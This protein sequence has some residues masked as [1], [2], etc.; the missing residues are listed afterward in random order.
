MLS[1]V[2][3]EYLDSYIFYSAFTAV[4][5]IS[6]EFGRHVESENKSENRSKSFNLGFYRLNGFREIE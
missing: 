1:A 6:P 4:V 5:A 2:L 3:F